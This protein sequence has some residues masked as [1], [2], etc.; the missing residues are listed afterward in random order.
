MDHGALPFAE[1]TAHDV[2]QVDERP[3][4]GA[5]VGGEAG[6]DACEFAGGET[7][8]AV[9]ENA[10]GVDDDRHQQTAGLDVLGEVV[11][12]VLG[13]HRVLGGVRVDLQGW[14]PYWVGVPGHRVGAPAW[15][16]L[17]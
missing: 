6:F 3:L 16:G 7:V 8:A 9:E 17:A 5:G 15:G 11:Q 1:V 13:K 12:L 4:V 2:G 10:V 14:S